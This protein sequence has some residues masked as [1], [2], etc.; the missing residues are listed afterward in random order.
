MLK[1]GKGLRGQL[2]RVISAVILVVVLAGSLV[3]YLH[4]QDVMGESIQENARISVAQ[5]AEIVSNWVQS[6]SRE[7]DALSGATGIKGMNWNEQL[8]LLEGILDGHPDYAGMFVADLNGLARTSAG[9][10]EELGD[11]PFFREIIS[12]GQ[13]NFSDPVR[14]PDTGDLVMLVGRPIIGFKGNMAGVLGAMVKLD[15]IRD[16]V[17]QLA[18]NGHGYGWLIDSNLNTVFHPEDKYIDNTRLLAENGELQT[19]AQR[20]RRGE[21][22]VD[23]YLHGKTEMIITAALVPETNWSLAIIAKKDDV[24][25]SLSELLRYN[26]AVLVGSL[27]I[28]VLLTFL[29][30]A[31]LV[32]PLLALE[33]R[34]EVMATG[35]LRGSVANTERDDEIGQL[36]TAFAQMVENMKTLITHIQR[37]GSRVQE[38]SS[39][40]FSG[41]QQTEGSISE[42][43]A[44]A[45]DFAHT[46]DVMNRN[47]QAV[48]QDAE[49]ITQLAGDG[50][51]A[52]E[53]SVTNTSEL[54]ADIEDLSLAINSLSESSTEISKI[55]NAIAAITEQTNLLALNAAIEAARAGEHGR[56]FAIVAEEVRNLSV[57]SAEATRTISALVEEIQSKTQLALEAMGNSV[58]KAQETSEVVKQGSESL[59]GVLDAATRAAKSIQE[60]S[61]GIIAI[62][63]GSQEIAATT[64][65]QSAIVEELALSAQE[66][67]SIA[68]DLIDLVRKFIVEEEGFH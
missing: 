7:I 11:S 41:I 38:Y 39:Q 19:I 33:E 31:R 8:P 27:I 13:T 42:M 55:A 61:A 63:D 4:V 36:A 14:S 30:A 64:E 18:I 3:S 26:L 57:Q 40:L 35:D 51:K 28:G 62:G 2:I 47:A 49:R 23:Y 21:N 53:L 29:I 66:L 9:S 65:E 1:L 56:G 45:T 34:A 17:D 32:K 15:Y 67:N 46:V 10:V 12:S 5:S 60:I 68:D 44:A 24:F 48:A 16:L 25:S 43:A 50:E 22:L 37:T 54:A 59:R 20:M 6:V 52:L 58:Q